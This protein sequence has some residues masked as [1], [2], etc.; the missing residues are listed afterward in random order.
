V[1]VDNIGACGSKVLAVNELNTDANVV[2]EADV[3]PVN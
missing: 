2:Y 3:I 1:A